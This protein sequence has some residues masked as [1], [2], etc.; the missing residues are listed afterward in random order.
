MVPCCIDYPYKTVWRKCIGLYRLISL[1]HSANNM[2]QYVNRVDYFV[3]GD[4]SEV[5]SVRNLLDFGKDGHSG[6]CRL[7]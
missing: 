2:H 4:V 6:V 7:S 1:P 3:N 5:G